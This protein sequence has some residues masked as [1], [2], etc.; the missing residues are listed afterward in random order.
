MIGAFHLF[1]LLPTLSY[2]QAVGLDSERFFV[3]V[4][5][6]L[7][8]DTKDRLA[9]T[10]DLVAV[11]QTERIEEPFA[12]A[13]AAQESK[14]RVALTAA[15]SA[16]LRNAP[17][18]KFIRPELQARPEPGVAAQVASI[19]QSADPLGRERAL[20]ALRF[21]TAGEL[22]IG[23]FYNHAALTAYAL[24]LA[25]VERWQKMDA[26]TGRRLVETLLGGSFCDPF[27]AA[28][29]YQ[30]EPGAGAQLP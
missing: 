10:L 27:A 5:R 18:R 2:G 30:P 17:L 8:R 15:R 23:H 14:L 4:E 11:C 3:L 9:A 6:F 25:I 28:L 20:D 7:G 22:A 21:R 1:A 24:Q 19:L 16:A 13:Y 26:D 29:P 12:R